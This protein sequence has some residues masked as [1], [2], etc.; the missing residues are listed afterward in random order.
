V[1]R[2]ERLDLIDRLKRENDEARER[3][4]QRQ[5][6]REQNP[7]LMDD[8][9]RE[10][11]R[12][13][14][15]AVY[16]EREASAGLLYREHHNEALQAAPVADAGAS[17][18]NTW[19][20]RSWENH[21]KAER[22]VVAEGIGEALLE[23]RKELRQ[24]H[25]AALVER[26]RRI[27]ALESEVRELTRKLAVSDDKLKDMRD[28]LKGSRALVVRLARLEGLFAGKMNQLAS[29]AD[30]AGTLPRGWED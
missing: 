12:E 28:D 14:V 3:L 29:F 25:A 7:E 16:V 18:W 22:Q 23:T 20:S 19:F 2:D 6:E 30:A 8:Y 26:D 17:D 24:E 10:C 13:P 15:R 9:L 1:T 5:E 27:S 4:R 11:D 21:I